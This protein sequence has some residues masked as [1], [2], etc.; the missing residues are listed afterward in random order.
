MVQKRMCLSPGQA[1][2]SLPKKDLDIL[3]QSL[4]TFETSLPTLNGATI[5]VPT[6]DS[7][8]DGSLPD[9]HRVCRPATERYNNT[10]GQVKRRGWSICR[11]LGVSSLEETAEEISKMR[12]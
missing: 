10:N 3:T 8:N 2:A 11:S 5:R 12:S 1:L 4:P 7:G 6:S 9:V